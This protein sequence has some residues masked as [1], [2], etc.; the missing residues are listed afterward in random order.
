MTLRFLLG[1]FLLVWMSASVNGQ[2]STDRRLLALEGKRGAMLNALI[3]P[4]LNCV[5]RRDTDH[6]V[7]HGC[8][9]WH[10]S[11]HGFWALTAAARLTGRDDLKD[12]VLSQLTPAAIGHEQALLRQNGN[13]EM[14]YGRAW[15]LRLAIE[16]ERTFDDRRLRPMADEITGAL[17]RHLSNRNVDPRA[18]SYESPTWALLNLRSYGR[19]AAKPELVSF[20]DRIVRNDYINLARR[21]SPNADAAQ[22]SFMAICTN[23]A[24]LVAEATPDTDFYNEWI[25]KFMPDAT[26]LQAVERPVSPHLY[27]LNFSRAWG[28][29]RIQRRSADPRFLALYV[30]HVEKNFADPEWWRGD[31]R[32][33]GHWVAQFGVFALMPLFEPD[34]F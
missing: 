13:F 34:Y 10:S 32:A 21:C 23:W 12:F 18:G 27:G 25:S 19:H 7:F 2:A 8:I 26:D 4:I 14:P 6:D 28:L 11:V 24:W 31:Y 17:M 33:N 29:W 30:Q 20:V 22:H 5:K 9:D 1:V 15:F 16:F 3:E